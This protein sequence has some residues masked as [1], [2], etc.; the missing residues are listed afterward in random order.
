MSAFALEMRKSLPPLHVGE[1]VLARWSDEGWYYRGTVKQSCGDGSYFVEDS[2]GD[3]EKIWRED[4][5]TDSDEADVVLQ[6]A[7][8]KSIGH[9]PTG[10]DNAE[11][12]KNSKHKL[13]C[14]LS[15]NPDIKKI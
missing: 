10:S 5:L 15:Y 2:V 4:I 14:S 6:V 8:L 13:V 3:L 9:T 11:K 12:F 1:E 7:G